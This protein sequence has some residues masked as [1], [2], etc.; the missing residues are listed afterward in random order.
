MTD[1]S[2][3]ANAA[4]NFFEKLEE[5]RD[6]KNNPLSDKFLYTG[7]GSGTQWT[8]INATGLDL[9]IGGASTIQISPE[10]EDRVREIVKE[11][12]KRLMQANGFSVITD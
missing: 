1:D 11:E 6:N 7:D 8:T 5:M 10:Y 9:G 2:N 3:T 4:E 12:F